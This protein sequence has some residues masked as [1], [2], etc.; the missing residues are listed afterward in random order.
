MYICFLCLFWY[1][2]NGAVVIQET[3]LTRSDNIVSSS[4]SLSYFRLFKLFERMISTVS[5]LVGAV[6]LSLDV[7]VVNVFPFRNTTSPVFSCICVYFVTVWHSIKSTWEIF[8]LQCS[9][10]DWTCVLYMGGQLSVSIWLVFHWSR[11]PLCTSVFPPAGALSTLKGWVV[12]NWQKKPI[13]HGHRAVMDNLAASTHS[14]YFKRSHPVA[15]KAVLYSR[16]TR[17]ATPFWGLHNNILL[18]L[19]THFLLHIMWT[20]F[21][22]VRVKNKSPQRWPIPLGRGETTERSWLHM[23]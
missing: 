23:S 12:E 15:L 19:S 9:P 6:F 20:V 3:F 2:A 11:P 13:P 21:I 16:V 22:K 4:S 14:S 7:V 5:F 1:V 17:A 10:W 18:L 8:I